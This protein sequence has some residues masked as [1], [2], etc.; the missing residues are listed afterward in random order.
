[1]KIEEFKEL[2][3][4]TGVL[5]NSFQYS[6]PALVKQ[7]L[8]LAVSGEVEINGSIAKIGIAVSNSFPFSK[9]VYYLLNRDDFDLLPHLDSDGN[10]CYSHN[11]TL[12]LD[13]DNPGGIIT[14]CFEMA[15]KTL[16]DGINRENDDEFYNEYEAYWLRIKDA[17]FAFAN[18]D[19]GEDVQ[20]IKYSKSKE[21][22]R[23]YAASDETDRIGAYERL[24][25]KAVS[26]QFCNGLHIPLKAGAKILIPSSKEVFTSGDVRKMIFENIAVKNEQKI[27]T[28]LSKT[29]TEDFIVCSLPQPNGNIA[30]FG[31]R[32][33]GISHAVHPLLRTDNNS[34]VI[35]YAIKRVDP[36]FMMMRGGTGHIVSEKKVLVIGGGSVGSAVCEELIKASVIHVDVVDKELLEVEN[37]YRHICGIKFLYEKKSDAIKDK[38]NSYYPHSKV[39]GYYCSIEEAVAKKRI[40]IKNYDAIVVATGN[41][42]SN[43]YLMRLFKKEI[44]GV[45]VFYSWL[46]PY[47]IGGHC[48]ITNISDKGCYGCLYTNEQLHNSASFADANQ[49][50]SFVKSIS[51][52]GSVYMPYG[53]LDAN[54]TAM[55]TVRKVLDVFHG[56]E[57]E[58]AIYS[59][60]GDDGDF[61]SNGFVL[62]K[63]YDLTV[64][65]LL[66]TKSK[67]YQTSCKICGNEIDGI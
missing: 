55:L 52:C 58:N 54:Q 63:R 56:K 48:L 37:C 14:A 22:E 10:I 16:S 7:G 2:V 13:S 57:S 1:M 19:L 60:K 46:D 15:I 41:A 65:E 66:E 43:H 64:E 20:V 38:L 47:G 44:P 6:T 31:F 51:G 27:R 50:K 40:S 53:S 23:V 12:V 61:V 67:F 28:I 24:F 25:S 62:S 33:K 49:S 8:E 29:K 39:N 42:T 45:P 36:E 35:P 5:K 21:K 59:W 32:L 9:P 17:G 30:L 18:I 26:P 11:D 34:I 3:E 4:E